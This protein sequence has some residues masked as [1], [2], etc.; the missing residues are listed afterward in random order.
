MIALVAALHVA[1]REFTLRVDLFDLAIKEFVGI[2]F[3]LGVLADLDQAE[4]W[5]GD[6]DADKELVFSGAAGL[7]P[8]AA[9]L[10]GWAL[11]GRRVEL[12]ALRQWHWRARALALRPS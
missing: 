4:L 11:V 3:D 12:K 10:F 6:K 5:F 8:A 7:F 1:W 9:P 2:C